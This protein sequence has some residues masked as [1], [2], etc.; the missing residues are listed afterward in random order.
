MFLYYNQNHTFK[1]KLYLRLFIGSCLIFLMHSVSAQ[2][3]SCNCRDY[4][5]VNE[6]DA[7]GGGGSGGGRVHKFA[8]DASTSGL[9]E[10]LNNGN[11]WYP[12]ANASEL[13]NP[14]GLGVDLNGYLYIGNT[15]QS[16]NQ[17]RRLTCDGEIKPTSEFV[18]NE[19]GVYLTNIGSYNGF[20][21]SN[22]AENRI[23]KWDPCT[24]TQVGY[25]QIQGQGSRKDDWGL[26]VSKT[27]IIYVTDILL[28]AIWVIDATDADFI[29][30]TSFPITKNLAADPALAGIYSGEGLA[31][32]TTDNVGNVYVVNAYSELASPPAINS[33][34]IKLDPNLNYISST[35][36]DN[37][38]DGTGWFWMLG[39]VYSE[40]SNTI[41]TTSRSPFEPCVY[42]WETDL[43]PVGSVVG[44]Q[45]NSSPNAHKGIAISTECCPLQNSAVYN[46]SVCYSG[47]QVKYYLNDL[48]S[49][50]SGV[51]CEGQ[52]EEIANSSNGAIVFNS[53]DLSI[54]V[55][56]FGCAE[57]K[58][59][60]TTSASGAQQCGPFSITFNVCSVPPPTGTFTSTPSTCSGGTSNNDG[61]ITLATATNAIRFGVSTGA[62]YNGPDYSSATDV[63]TLPQDVETGISNSGGTYT[64]RLFGG[65]NDCFIDETITVS[66][67]TCPPACVNPTAGTPVVTKATCNAAGTAAN[68]DA[69]IAVSNVMNGTSYAFSTTA[70]A[71]T[72]AGAIAITGGAFTISAQP[73]P[74]ASTTYTIRIFNGSATC[75]TDITA[76]LTPTVCTPTCVTP[77][78]GADFTI[79]LPKTTLDLT[80]APSGNE[81]MAVTG[82]PATAVINATT[83][84]ITG[85]TATGVYSF[86]LQKTG[87]ATCSDVMTVTV[88]NGEA[89]NVLCNDGST[90]VT[91]EA[92]ANLTNVK[93]YSMDGTEVGAG[94]SLIVTSNTGGLADGTEAYYY[95]GEDGTASGCAVELCCPV[96]FLTQD[97]C[98]TPNCAGV[99]VIKN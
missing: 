61:K 24:G 10:I 79:C 35:P 94:N 46:Q 42:A 11:P 81:W 76:T 84:V 78:A 37:V 7:S 13:P 32:I 95:I 22:G 29:S 82:N 43:T 83:G 58:I 9:T 51:V 50:G 14:H 90:S 44:P 53:C 96:K 3:R 59:E 55:N 18:I 71:P 75:F 19:P 64:V 39:I 28:G 23:Y 97:C 88:T 67:V 26:H 8:V 2:R 93:W 73:N 66:P 60:K 77:D 5:Y 70:T 47:Q 49:C 57:F 40:S 87:D 31:G 74:A 30:H 41:Y 54:T 12:G 92:P 25:V 20:I 65:T 63:G 21:Y 48:L 86:R 33:R 52:W 36:I 27:G 62:T 72:F 16:P 68:N 1:V 4:L 45:P 15:A 99:T 34:L 38:A 80:D 98:P 17:I 91:L 89:P 69:S 56:G 6:V 85:M